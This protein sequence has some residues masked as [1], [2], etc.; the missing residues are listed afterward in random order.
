MKILF[1]MHLDGAPWSGEPAAMGEARV[2]PRGLLGILE[3]ELGLSRPQVHPVHRIDGYMKRLEAA[4]CESAWFHKSFDVDPWSTSRQLLKW[5]DQ[6]VEAGWTGEALETESIRLRTLSELELPDFPIPTGY[7]ERIREAIGRLEKGFPVHIGSVCL[8]E[9]RSLLPPVWRKL[10]SLL[11]A[12]GATISERNQR[13]M[14]TEGSNLLRIQKGLLGEEA[15]GELNPEDDS[16]VLLK[17]ENEWEA[18]ET[19]ALWLSSDRKENKAV[20]IICGRDTRVLDQSLKARGLPRLGRGEP[21]VWRER[22]QILPLVLANAWIPVDIRRLVEVLSLSMAPFPKWVCKQLL[23]AVAEEPGVG[24][25]AWN[26]AL[27]GIEERIK[28]EKEKEG[29]P[30]AEELASAYVRRIQALLVEDRFDPAEGIPEEKLRERCAVVMDLIGWRLEQ[31]PALKEIVG[32]VREMQEL[33]HGKGRI[34][35]LTLERILDAVIGAGDLPEDVFEEAGNWETADHPGQVVDTCGE[36]VWWGFNDG[37]NASVE[38]WSPDEREALRRAGVFLEEPGLLRLREAHAWRQAALASRKRLV[39]VHIAGID[40]EEA[41]HHPFWDVILCAARQGEAAVSETRAEAVLVREC[42]E[43]EHKETWTFAGRTCV[44]KAV[45]E[46]AP[47]PVAATRKIP[48]AVVPAPEKLSYSQMSTL[49]GCPMKWAL[50]YHAGL[51]L[52]ESQAIPEGNQMIGSLCHRIIEELYKEGGWIDADEAR[53]KAENLFDEL[54]PSMASELLLDG[55]SIRR[56]RTRHAVIEAVGRLVAAVNGCRLRVERTEAPLEG[57]LATETGDIFFSGF[58]DLLLRDEDG[59][60]FVLDLK[61]SNSSKYKKKEVEDGRALQL[62]VYAWML[63]S[64]EPSVPVH[65]GYFMLAQGEMLTDSPALEKEPIA[66]ARTL[67]ETWE[68]GETEVEEA[69]ERLGSGVLEAKGVKELQEAR[70][71]KIKSDK[72]REELEKRSLEEGWLYISPPCKFCDFGHLC[73]FTGG[74]HE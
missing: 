57:R 33:S 74:A 12:Q 52:P 7:P 63:R 9:P 58:S 45:S 38:F 10:L 28:L 43:L 49:I 24:G 61:W 70:E 2:G 21:S 67:E 15:V 65:A 64:A 19:L 59:R 32:Q 41:Y 18:A 73:G 56:Q 40:G 54:V 72:L 3:S 8:T 69:V 31:D 22:Q 27:S 35:R 44:L 25:R 51:R 23:R 42:R 13:P 62:A 39:A 20:S 55:Q 36:L 1:G 11:E 50:Q 66:S 71:R 37:G 48:E 46:A 53:G 16:V 29:D 14:G 17:A 6:L 47:E 60:T 4:D 30:K 34:P 26:Q 5:R 68:L